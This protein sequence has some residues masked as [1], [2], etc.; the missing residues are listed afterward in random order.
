MK[1]LFVTQS[2]FP[3]S[4]GRPLASYGYVSEFQK[5]CD[6]TLASPVRGDEKTEKATID[7][8]RQHG[9]KAILVPVTS[10]NAYLDIVSEVPSRIKAKLTMTVPL[11]QKLYREICAFIKDNR[12]ELVIIDHIG[13]AQYFRR[14]QKKFPNVEF[15]YNSHNVEFQN[16]EAELLAKAGNNPIKRLHAS[17]RCKMRKNLERYMIANSK[18][19]FC[20]SRNDMD[21]LAKEFGFKEKF[22]F[23]KPLIEFPRTKNIDDVR[24]Y[25]HKLLIVGSMNWYPN[26]KGIVWFVKNVFTKLKEKD[27]NLKLY[28]VGSKPTSEIQNLASDSVIV[29]GFVDST[30]PYFKECD[31]SIIPVFEGTGAKIK[32]LESI[33]RGIPTVC[34]DFA[35]KDYDFSDNALLKAT[36]AEEFEEAIERLSRSADIREELY[37]KMK[38]YYAEYFHLSNE[39]VNVIS[40]A[41]NQKEK[42]NED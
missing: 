27:P 28:L 15:V 20:I 12:V 21:T 8:C 38:E 9:I 3:L 40:K 33:A 7:F 22:V 36:S 19:V 30:D 18:N 39:V 29:T 5:Y 35:A 1:T 10:H 26:V 13:M 24:E 16:T 37:T 14:I 31:I 6:L 17:L 11:Y 32:V 41:Q 25:H 34:V 23:S 42:T 4:G 2:I